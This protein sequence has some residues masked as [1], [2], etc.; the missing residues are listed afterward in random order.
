MAMTDEERKAAKKLSRQK[1]KTKN[2]DKVKEEKKKYFKAHP[3]ILRKNVKLWKK[4]NPE[5]R[6]KIRRRLETKKRLANQLG[7]SVKEVP[8]ELLEARLAMNDV[9]RKV[10]ELSK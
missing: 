3:E 6:R 9:K 4:A 5:A 2:P 1:W 10:K 7:V 8:I